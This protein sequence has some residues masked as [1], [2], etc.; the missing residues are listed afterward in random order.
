MPKKV[1]SF[2]NELAQKAG[3]NGDDENLK[4]VMAIAELQNIDLPDELVTGIDN[5]LL[6]ITEAKNNHPD[7]K[8]Y[9]NAMALNGVD[10]RL[11]QLMEELQV[12]ADVKA[13]ILNER[14]T[15]ERAALLTKKIKEL[16]AAKKETTDKGEKTTLQKEIDELHSKLR[17]SNE[18]TEK[19][20]TEYEGRISDIEKNYKLYEALSNYKTIFDGLPADARNV[21][22]VS[23][24]NKTLQDKSAK[25]ELDENGA[26]KLVRKDGS[27]VFGDDNRPWTTQTLIDQAL[28]QNKVLKV[29][30]PKPLN[31]GI[32]PNPAVIN[33]NGDEGNGANPVPRKKDSTLSNLVSASLK[34]IENAKT[35]S[36]M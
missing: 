17:S 19:L 20:K 33:G 36:V 28:S 8:R 1:S 7:I 5:N 23:L 30:D 34:D 21:S 18:A 26:L 11:N 6:S 31:S 13:V 29:T 27:N 16:E 10:T 15:P 12:P 25:L 22:L 24:V 4:K 32:N 35:V 2:I 9:Y 3:V 14:S